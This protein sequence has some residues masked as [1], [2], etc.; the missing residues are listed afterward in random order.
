MFITF[1]TKCFFCIR[2]DKNVKHCAARQ[3]AITSVGVRSEKNPPS[4]AA[5]AAAKGVA[6]TPEIRTGSYMFTL[7]AECQYALST[8]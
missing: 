1:Y 7:P 2:Q 4:A 8:A 3:V 5:A 6:F